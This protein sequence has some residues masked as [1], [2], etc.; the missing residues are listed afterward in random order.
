MDVRPLRILL[1]YADAR[2]A[3]MLA[4][5][6]HLAG[7]AADGVTIVSDAGAA[8]SAFAGGGVHAVVA[9]WATPGAVELLRDIRADAVSGA[10]P[11]TPFIAT[12]ERW[13]AAPAKE[14]ASAGVHDCLSLPLSTDQVIKRI[15]GPV[16]DPP[17]FVRTDGYFG[18]DR[19]ARRPM[20]R[21]E[22]TAALMPVALRSLSD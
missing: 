4:R 5:L 21:G 12:E 7:I 22:N 18:P 19:R 9:D 20:R 16:F 15:L 6:L 8:R 10:N 11:V 13:R 17:P 1:V 14:A 3:A 2:D